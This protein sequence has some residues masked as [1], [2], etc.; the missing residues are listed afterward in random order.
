[1]AVVYAT[2]GLTVSALAAISAGRRGLIQGRCDR[3]R[4]ARIG[5]NRLAVAASHA[6]IAWK[7]P[8]RARC[9]VIALD[10]HDLRANAARAHHHEGQR[11]NAGHQRAR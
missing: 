2:G 10:S 9:A 1:V 5:G 4:T 3:Q 7:Y 11:R 6:I 8:I